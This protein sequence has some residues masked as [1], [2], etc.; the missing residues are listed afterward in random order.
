MHGTDES[1]RGESIR[2]GAV[3][4]EMFAHTADIGL[5]VTA[6]DEVSLLEGAA[7]GM[8]WCI[9]DLIAA[10][11][12]ELRT[13]RVELSAADRAELLR[14]WLAELLYFVDHDRVTLERI[15]FRELSPGRVR[16]DWIV[17]PYD[18]EASRL[19]REIKAVTYHALRVEPTREGWCA[20]VIFDI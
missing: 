18:P 2:F 7:R 6:P 9:G 1:D 8:L 10:P 16:A 3:Q 11:G 15:E 14:D 17:A 5:R 20:E 4:C 19:R 12:A 13:R